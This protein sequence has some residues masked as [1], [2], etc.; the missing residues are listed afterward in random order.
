M[1]LIC[2]GSRDSGPTQKLYGFFKA[3]VFKMLTFVICVTL[4]CHVIE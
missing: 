3:H 2:M 4:F 1:P